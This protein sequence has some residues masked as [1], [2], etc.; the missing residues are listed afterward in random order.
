MGHFGSAVAVAVLVLAPALGCAAQAPEHRV[1]LAHQR[2]DEVYAEYEVA[3]GAVIT[4]TWIHSI[5]LSPWTDYYRVEIPEDG[6]EPHLVLASTEFEEY[7]AGMPLDE[8]DVTFGGGR[9]RID[10]ID[11]KFDTISWF[12]SHKA[13]YELTVGDRVRISADQLPDRE[14][15]ELRI[16]TAP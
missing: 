1:V 9:I 6:S 15:I 3:Q 7:G 16:E 12:H 14:P 11:R 2:T 4:Q 5:E 10:N 13:E 8:G